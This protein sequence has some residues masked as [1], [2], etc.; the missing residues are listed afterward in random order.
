MTAVTG[1]AY[2]FLEDVYPH[3]S[4]G[5]RPLKTPG[6]IKALFPAE[7]IQNTRPTA[8]PAPAA[9]AAPAAPNF[10]AP[11]VVPPPVG[12]S[13]TLL[14]DAGTLPSEQGTWKIRISCQSL[15]N[16]FCPI[17]GIVVLP[18][19]GGSILLVAL[20]KHVSVTMMSMPTIMFCMHT[21]PRNMYT[22]VC[23][24]LVNGGHLVK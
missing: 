7:Q 20:W 11:G 6:L 14:I 24:L 22:G 19:V 16:S 5:R 18:P 8:A 12:E 13:I 9:P 2:Y 4:H 23:Q 21:Q 15:P 10:P 17:L 3:M 1:H